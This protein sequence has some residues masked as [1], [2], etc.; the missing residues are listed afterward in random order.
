MQIILFYQEISKLLVV[1]PS[2]S[3]LKNYLTCILLHV[4]YLS[5]HYQN[6]SKIHSVYLE[7]SATFLSKIVN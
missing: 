6:L 4:M 2:S 1:L 3:T 5:P 7:I